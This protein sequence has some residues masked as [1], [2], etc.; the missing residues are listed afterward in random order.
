MGKSAEFKLTQ[1]GANNSFVSLEL[2]TIPS[3]THVGPSAG[4]NSARD[5]GN[6]SQA[7]LDTKR[8]FR[9][10]KEGMCSLCWLAKPDSLRR[11]RWKIRMRSYFPLV[12][13]GTLLP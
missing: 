7:H 6:F 4:P 12:F 5:A 1:P 10:S 11:H 2:L 3:E 8:G 9:K 13:P